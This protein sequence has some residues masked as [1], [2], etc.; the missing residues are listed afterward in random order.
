METN[1]P[2]PWDDIE[3]YANVYFIFHHSPLIVCV[4]SHMKF[5]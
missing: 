3:K 4:I 1:I 5:V 2:F